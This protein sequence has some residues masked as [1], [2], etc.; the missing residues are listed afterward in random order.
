[1]INQETQNCQKFGLDHDRSEID[2]GPQE[3]RSWLCHGT[4]DR[5]SSR[6]KTAVAVISQSVAIN[7]R[8]QTSTHG[9]VHSERKSNCLTFVMNVIAAGGT[10]RHS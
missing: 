8:A 4:S 6:T 2:S 3:T 10:A 5:K 7:I 9:A 1:M